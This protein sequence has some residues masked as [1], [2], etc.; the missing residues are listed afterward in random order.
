M[1]ALDL[2]ADAA[3]LAD[4]LRHEGQQR[5]VPGPLDGGG[6][7]A[8]VLGAVTALAPRGNLAPVRD[9]RP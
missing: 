6:E 3:G 1:T 8:L 2:D 4:M 9:I 7:G 5:Q